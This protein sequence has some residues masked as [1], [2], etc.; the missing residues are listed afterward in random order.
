MTRQIPHLSAN[1]NHRMLPLCLP[2][3]QSDGVRFFL[4]LFLMIPLL[5]SCGETPEQIVQR[6]DREGRHYLESGQYVKA[7]DSWDQIRTLDPEF[8]DLY[9]N[10]AQAY[11]GCGRFR[12]ALA[13]YQEYLSR[14]PDSATALI[15]SM[16]IQLKL[17]D[18]TGAQ[19]SWEQ[20]KKLPP[21]PQS[22]IVHGDFLVVREQYENAEKEY[23]K[24]LEISPNNPT[25][26]ARLAVLL[27]GR[28]RFAEAKKYYRKLEALDPTDPVILL[29]MGNYLLL[30]GQAEQ[31]EAVFQ[32]AVTLA[33]DDQEFMLKL[34]QVYLAGNR[35][36]KAAELFSRLQEKFPQSR[37]YKKMLL[38]TLLHSGEYSRAESLLESLSPSENRDIDYMLIKGKFY[39]NMGEY[40]LAVSQIE[41]AVEQEPTLPMLHYYLALA[42]LAGG[43]NNLGQK[44]LIKCLQLN[45]L[46]TEAELTLAD[47]YY[48]TKEY[49]LALEHARRIQQR[50]PENPRGFFVEGNV[51][52]AMGQYGEALDSFGKA[53]RLN[54][55]RSTVL[56][57]SARIA[58]LKGD[59]RQAR[60][61]Y[62]QLLADKPTLAD[63]ALLYSRLALKEQK[64]EALDYLENNIAALPNNPYLH[65]IHGLI[66]LETGR[67]EDADKAF[68]RALQLDPEMREPYLRLFELYDNAPEKLEKT[69]RQALDNIKN[70]DD[71]LIRLSS[72]Y[73]RQG[74]SEEAISLLQEA[75]ASEP[76]APIP[77]NNLALL[78]LQ[79]QPDNI[80]EALRLAT[81]AYDQLPE[82]GAAADTLGWIYYHKHS[83]T[84]S[85]WLL[86]EAV[87]LEPE[88]PEIRSHLDTVL[89]EQ[90]KGDNG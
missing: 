38:E 60:Q 11:Q 4:L 63:A 8:P 40:L 34:A 36:S 88:N 29:Q 65:Y 24:A 20:L 80:D 21:T 47:Y 43:Q 75:M 51:Q 61:L 30:A 10:L 78:Y 48:T 46:F 84:R 26:L 25:A 7:V 82:N 1:R 6:L 81:L 45:P 76:N 35:Y 74:R 32:H 72:L 5:S 85:R 14:R 44:S 9:L 57:Y 90:Q 22:L 18:M 42:H 69:L 19:G 70:F 41:T 31:A 66:L 71:A 53:Y 55:A 58:D 83:L 15:G 3:F 64:E 12:Q 87:K 39:L 17:F 86:E 50:E 37:Y 13:S 52:L 23:L 62:R 77:A 73:A 2:F 49:D 89:Q 79:Y 16:K 27:E 59:T 28:R 67:T 68:H 56:Y 54:G 33:P